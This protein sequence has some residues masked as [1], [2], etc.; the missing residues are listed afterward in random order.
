MGIWLKEE[1]ERTKKLKALDNQAN[2][3]VKLLPSRNSDLQVRLHGPAVK[4]LFKLCLE[5]SKV[6]ETAIKKLMALPS[7]VRLQ[8]GLDARE[9]FKRLP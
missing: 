5:Q 1:E 3:L 9:L 2:D 4:E 8:F 6:A 7:E